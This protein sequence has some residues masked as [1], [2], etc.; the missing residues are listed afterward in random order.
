MSQYT[1]GTVTVTNGLATVIG[2]LTLW[3]ANVQPGDYFVVVGLPGED[4]VYEINAIPDDTTLT[5]TAPFG[6]TTGGSRAYTIHRDFDPNGLPIFNRTDVALHSILNRWNI[7]IQT[8]IGT[9]GAGI[10]ANSVGPTQLQASGVTPDTYINATVTV[11]ENGIVTLA[12]NGTAGAAVPLIGPTFNTSRT[13]DPVADVGLKTQFDVQLNAV[14]LTLPDATLFPGGVEFET[15]VNSNANLASVTVAVPNQLRSRNRSA[16]HDSTAD[17]VYLGLSQATQSSSVIRFFV[18]SGLWQIDG[19]FREIPSSDLNTPVGQLPSALTPIA[20]SDIDPAVDLDV[21]W[22]DSESKLKSIAVQ[23]RYDLEIDRPNAD[24]TIDASARAKTMFAPT[25]GSI[26]TID[27]MREGQVVPFR[28]KSGA[29]YTF[30]EGAGVTITGDTTVASNSAANI[31]ALSP[32]DIYIDA[33][34]P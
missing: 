30:A 21:V 13:Y 33:V 17:T 16:A 27:P 24:F 1:E 11:D 20:A 8:L 31:E 29:G 2:D 9:S 15:R 26:C 34:I 22:D 25:G 19:L 6:G 3:L 23:E 18:R 5:L 12:S 10:P 14:Q 7:L 32:T 4:Q 28:N